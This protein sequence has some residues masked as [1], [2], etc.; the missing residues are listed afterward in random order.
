MPTFYHLSLNQDGTADLLEAITLQGGTPIT[1]FDNLRRVE[2][3]KKPS[4]VD[5]LD[6]EALVR[7]SD[8]TFWLASEESPSLLHVAADGQIL[9][10]IVPPAEMESLATAS[11]PVH[12]TLPSVLSAWRDNRGIEALGLSPDE[13]YL[14]FTTQAPLA[15]PDTARLR[16]A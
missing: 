9:Q 1:G 8:G 15:H 4:Q 13:Q 6:V 3:G 7:L 16:A 12:G 11:Y 5:Q 10:R 2:K 14:Y